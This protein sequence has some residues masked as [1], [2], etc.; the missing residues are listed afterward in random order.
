MIPKS[1]FN[2]WSVSWNKASKELA[3]QLLN[4]G[5]WYYFNGKL[6]GDVKRDV[7]QQ[8]LGAIRPSKSPAILVEFWNMSQESQAYILR[9]YTKREELAKNFVSSLIKVYKK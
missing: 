2:M 8:H 9:E 4:N 5:F 7:V 6:A 3:K 1:F